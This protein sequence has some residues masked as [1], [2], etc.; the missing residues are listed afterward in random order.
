MSAPRPCLE[1]PRSAPAVSISILSPPLPELDQSLLGVGGEEAQEVRAG[2]SG[3]QSSGPD[4]QYPCNRR[5]HG[6]WQGREVSIELRGVRGAAA[7][8]P[9]WPTA[10]A[11]LWSA[12]PLPPRSA[13]PG[14]C[15]GAAAPG[16]MIV[17]LDPERGGSGLGGAES[18][19]RLPQPRT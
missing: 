3:V 18:E 12:K 15:G 4:V 11:R 13:S 14:L 5:A 2:R 16:V 1:A 17:V 9:H 7:G 6:G 19:P 8:Q 10:C